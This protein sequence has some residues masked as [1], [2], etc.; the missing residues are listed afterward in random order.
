MEARA[1]AVRDA[2]IRDG[3]VEPPSL[4][5][6]INE[7]RCIG[8]RSCIA[9]CPEQ[10]D[11]EVLGLINGKAHLINP[12]DCIGHG[13]CKQVCPVDAIELVFGT[14]KRGIDIPQVKPNFETY[15]PGIVICG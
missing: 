12:S 9:V 10:P 5:P 4:H 14:S 13:A 1:A 15:V 3:L 7:S 6:I 11:H 2:A 8:C